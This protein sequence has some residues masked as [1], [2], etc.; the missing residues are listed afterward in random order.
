M[1]AGCCRRDRS[2]M[3]AEMLAEQA[4]EPAEEES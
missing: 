4:F 1:T 3:R 2:E